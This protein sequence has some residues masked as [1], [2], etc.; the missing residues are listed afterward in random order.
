VK[1]ADVKAAGASVVGKGK[2]KVCGRRA[3]PTLVKSG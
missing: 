2:G 1:V 3:G